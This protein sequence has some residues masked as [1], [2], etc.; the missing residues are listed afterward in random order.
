M[1]LLIILSTKI[2]KAILVVYLLSFCGWVSAQTPASSPEPSE[3]R[4]VTLPLIV[5]SNEKRSIDDLNKDDIQLSENGVAQTV[6]TLSLDTRPIDYAVAIDTSGS[7]RNLLPYA[8]AAA[9]VLFQSNRSEDE[10]FLERFISSDKIETV[11][12]FTSDRLLLLKAADQLYVEGGQSAV[13]DAVYLAAL[14]VAGHH[15]GHDH[16]RAVI[17]ISD[18]E[19]R[20]SYYSS[21]KLIEWLR[22]KDVQV[23]AIGIVAQLDKQGITINAR[24]KAQQLLNR[25]AAESGGRAFFPNTVTDLNEALN[26]IVHDLHKQFLVSYQPTN[27]GKENFQKTQVTIREIPERPKLTAITKTGYFINP[28]KVDPKPDKKKKSS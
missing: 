28:P 24:S 10:T 9:K 2:G 12:E 22:V 18:G 3:P 14:H 8:I 1:N 6:A 21:D 27:S 23:F 13:V 11:Q 7:F 19:D 4:S 16:R 5:I 17:L 26:E 20:A 25:L 15:D